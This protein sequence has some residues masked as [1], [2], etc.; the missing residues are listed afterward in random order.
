[1]WILLALLSAF[2]L[3]FYDVFKKI[4][5][6]ENNVPVVLLLNTL[7]G[8]LLMSPVLI[9][10][11]A[12]GYWGLGRLS[13]VISGLCLKPLSFFHHGYWGISPSNTFL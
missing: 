12:D 1:M 3:G 13:E 4:S 10:G 6:K 8:T 7:F 2:C 9:G 11:I 5:L